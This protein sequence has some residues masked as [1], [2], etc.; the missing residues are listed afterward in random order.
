MSLKIHTNVLVFDKQHSVDENC[1]KLP[2]PVN[3]NRYLNA[4]ES[5]S[6]DAF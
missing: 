1:L 5:L 6:S 4:Y 2:K 3:K